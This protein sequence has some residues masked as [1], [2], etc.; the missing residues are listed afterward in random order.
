MEII[1]DAKGNIFYIEENGIIAEMT[2]RVKNKN[3]MVIDHTWV[4]QM[5]R[6][7]GLARKLVDTGVEYARSNNM[8][9]HPVCSYVLSLFSKN[10]EIFNDIW[11]K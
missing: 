7:D 5:Y 3:I 4:D 6:K 10:P 8:K 11:D 9:I 1:H 2:Y